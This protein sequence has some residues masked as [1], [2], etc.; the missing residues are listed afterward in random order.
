MHIGWYFF[1]SVGLETSSWYKQLFFVRKFQSFY[2][3]VNDVSQ[4]RNLVFSNWFD[5]QDWTVG[6]S[7]GTTVS[8]GTKVSRDF[9]LFSTL[10]C[11]PVC[12]S[13]LLVLFFRY[14][15]DETMSWSF[16]G[17]SL[18]IFLAVSLKNS[19]NADG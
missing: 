2:Q 16:S 3:L 15:S 18:I 6:I 5:E 8:I 9:R 19:F 4:R 7:I 14:F 10:W 17:L 12:S 1:S 11:V 13:K